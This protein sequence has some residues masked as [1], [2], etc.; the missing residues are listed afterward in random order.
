M[1]MMM[2]DDDDLMNDLR[3]DW[4]W[5]MFDGRDV[6]EFELR[7]WECESELNEREMEWR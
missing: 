5:N 4:C 7:Y 2:V 1:K 6:S 3:F